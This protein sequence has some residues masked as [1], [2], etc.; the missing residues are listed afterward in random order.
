MYYDKSCFVSFS[1]RFQII[2]PLIETDPIKHEK[3][4]QI[5]IYLG[6]RYMI[7]PLCIELE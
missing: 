4:K 1:V 2:R 7:V 5:L 6:L 3:K